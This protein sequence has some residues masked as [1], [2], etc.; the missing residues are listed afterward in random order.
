[1]QLAYY[2][3]T[4]GTGS[5]GRPRYFGVG[6]WLGDLVVREAKAMVPSGWVLAHGGSRKLR[7][8]EI[9]TGKYRTPDPYYGLRGRVLLR[10]LSPNDFKIETKQDDTKDKVDENHK[11]VDRDEVVN[12]DVLLAMGR[13]LASIHRGTPDRRKAI[14]A[15]LGKRGDRWLLDAMAAARMKVE[16]DFAVWAAAHPK[17]KEK[18]KKKASK[19]KQTKKTKRMKKKT[20]KT[21]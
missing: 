21:K 1:V 17:D 3:R 8:E 13:D 12:A 18:G 2:E 14:L 5:L 20:K 11:V 4:A 15:D 19:A 9:A 10:R 6:A 7:C 16:A